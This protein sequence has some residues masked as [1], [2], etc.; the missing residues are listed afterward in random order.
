MH[1]YYVPSVK[2]VAHIFGLLQKFQKKLPKVNNH[3]IGENSPNLATLV[4]GMYLGGGLR[5]KIEFW[6]PNK[7]LST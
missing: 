3:P 2:K 4:V 1:N 7:K 6:I 5:C